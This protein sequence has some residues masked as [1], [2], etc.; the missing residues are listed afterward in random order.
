VN[1][2]L[3][4]PPGA[5]KGTQGD[6]LSKD[7]NLIKISTGDLLRNEIKKKNKIGNEIKSTIDKGKFVSDELINSL[8]EENLKKKDYSNKLIFDGY[9]RNL[10]QAKKFDLLLKKY[11]QKL[12]CVISLNIE[13]TIIVKRV[14]GRQICSECGLIFNKYYNAATS[15]NHKCNPNFLVTRADDNVST[16]EKRHDTYIKETYPIKKHYIDQN[17]LH[18][19][20]GSKKIDQIYEEIRNIIDSLE[21]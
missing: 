3:F 2:I 19:V 6:K 18:D 9:P 14:S 4:G 20:D 12:S 7:Y 16:V 11:D 13:K 8:V 10:H 1:L 15:N 17:L 5:G 21:T